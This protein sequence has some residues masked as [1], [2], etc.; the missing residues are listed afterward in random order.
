MERDDPIWWSAVPRPVLLSAAPTPP[1]PS[2]VMPSPT[3]PRK[4]CTGG[5]AAGG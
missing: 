1:L 5:G 2:M 4:L 3:T